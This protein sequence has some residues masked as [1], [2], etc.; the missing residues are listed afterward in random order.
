MLYTE[1][2]EEYYQ[3]NLALI[4]PE[5]REDLFRGAHPIYTKVRDQ[6]PSYYGESC[7]LVNCTLADGCML[8]GSISNSVLFRHVRI[9]EGAVIEDSV[10]MNDTVVGEG[11]YLKCVILDKDV[12]VSPGARL[13]GTPTNPII[14][15]R[16][17]T[18]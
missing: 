4:R 3:A 1:S 18:V 13:V 2:T 8:E 9:G 12:V 11:A 5:I 7:R 10:I 14:L 15:K 16:G 6:V 17:E